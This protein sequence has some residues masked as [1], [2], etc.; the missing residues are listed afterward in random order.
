MDRLS[1]MINVMRPI[2]AYNLAIGDLVYKELQT[3]DS[4]FGGI[5]EEVSG[6]LRECFV[7]T[8][9]G[10]G[11][12]SYE[13]IIGAPRDDL[14]LQTRRDMIIRLMNIG[15]NDFTPDGIMRF[16]DSLDFECIIL[17]EPELFHVTIVPLG[18]EYSRAE[19][20][21]IIARAKAFLPCHLSFTIEF[22]QRTWDD[23]DALDKTFDEWEALNMTWDKFDRYEG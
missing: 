18:R 22:A 3:Y 9:T 12:V 23:L 8:A 6:V 15:S 1:S 11:L 4:G 10:D 16:F 19:Q 7:P 5:S 21:F 14:D 17:E 2:G 20:D 13:K